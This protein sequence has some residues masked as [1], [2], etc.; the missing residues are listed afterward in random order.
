MLVIPVVLLVFYILPFAVFFTSR[1]SPQTLYHFIRFNEIVDSLDVKGKTEIE[2][3]IVLCRYVG[4]K[5]RNHKNGD[6]ID[7]V[8][9]YEILE[10]GYGA[11]DQKA[12]VLVALAEYTGI[13]GYLVYLYG[14]DSVSHHTVA[15]LKIND[16][17]AMFD[18]YFQHQF[19]MSETKLASVQDVVERKVTVVN[20]P[21]IDSADYARLFD[22]KYPY[23]VIPRESVKSTSSISQQLLQLSYT[24]YGSFM[25]TPWKSIYKEK[26]AGRMP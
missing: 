5:V 11:C 8:S 7:D 17:W 14:Y 1:Q 4:A 16:S 21:L 25:T 2:K 26:A 3:A 24:I 23:K 9:A 22:S 13:E 19:R 6:K 12:L 20:L 18:P 15:E 10:K